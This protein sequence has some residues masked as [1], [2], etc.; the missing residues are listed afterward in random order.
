MTAKKREKVEPC[1]D[2]KTA[3][4][5]YHAG[6]LGLKQA[7]EMVNRLEETGVDVRELRE[8]LKRGKA[9]Q[10]SGKHLLEITFTNHK[11]KEKEV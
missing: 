6:K 10:R 11:P 8:K 3:Q 4:A 5:L 2:L 1:M 9:A 7:T